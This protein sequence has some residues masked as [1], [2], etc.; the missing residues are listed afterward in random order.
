MRQRSRIAMGP[1]AASL[2]LIVVIL[3]MSVLGILSLMNSR[4]DMRLTERSTQVIRAVYELNERAEHS[5][6]ALDAI[7]AEAEKEENVLQKV[8][9]NLPEGMQM[10]GSVVS[11]TET[12]GLRT[13]DCAVELHPGSTG[14][15]FTWLVH[16][17]TAITEE[18]WD[19]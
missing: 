14:E 6:A 8:A 13:L 9:E 5:L 10:N 18:V 16:R 7:L 19:F 3:S 15:R 1:G 2:I 17:L 4:N 12:D 11:W